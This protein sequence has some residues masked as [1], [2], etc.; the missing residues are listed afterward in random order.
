M[1]SA[2]MRLVALAVLLKSGIVIGGGGRGSGKRA[3]LL[4]AELPT[5]ARVSFEQGKRR[6]EMRWL[7]NPEAGGALGI[8][9]P[10]RQ[11]KGCTGSSGELGTCKPAETVSESRSL[12]Q[13]VI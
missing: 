11:R 5:M 8:G 6:M 4:E 1:Q 7:G 13:G 12:L 2:A 3:A 10:N 9:P